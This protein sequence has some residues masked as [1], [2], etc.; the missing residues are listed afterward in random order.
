MAGVVAVRR[1]GYTTIHYKEVFQLGQRFQLEDLEREARPHH[2]IS[3]EKE[4]YRAMIKSLVQ[5]KDVTLTHKK[6][7]KMRSDLITIR[8]Q[9]IYPIDIKS[10]NYVGGLLVDFGTAIT[11]PHFTFDICTDWQNQLTRNTDLV[12]FDEMIEDAGV[13]TRVKAWNKEYVE[14]LRLREKVRERYPK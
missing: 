4:F 2:Y 6:V 5:D 14:R 3:P 12:E 9:G 10:S 7:K 1:Y 13:K 11:E 8:E